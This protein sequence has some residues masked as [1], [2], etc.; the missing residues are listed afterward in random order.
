[1]GRAGGAGGAGRADPANKLKRNVDGTGRRRVATGRRRRASCDTR[2]GPPST[3]NPALSPY[4]YVNRGACAGPAPLDRFSTFDGSTTRPVRQRARQLV[5]PGWR[6]TLARRRRLII[7]APRCEV[8][9]TVRR[10]DTIVNNIGL[11]EFHAVFSLLSNNK[12]TRH[13]A[14]MNIDVALQHEE[15]LNAA[16]RPQ[17]GRRASV[18]TIVVK[19]Y[20]KSDVKFM[21]HL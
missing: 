1:M 7:R 12:A 16:R 15:L 18:P 11:K 4:F 3:A 21:Y 20:R 6:P 19:T 8:T 14:Q 13:V 17:A 9:S 5:G 10:T 2:D